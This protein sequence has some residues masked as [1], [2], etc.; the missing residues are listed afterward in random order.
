MLTSIE[1]I[2]LGLSHSQA[3]AVAPTLP[4]PRGKLG[5]NSFPIRAATETPTVGESM[6]KI[7]IGLRQS[8]ARARLFTPAEQNAR[9]QYGRG[10]R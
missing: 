7:R 2:T 3:R 9:Y 4:I 1:K 8:A 5:L 10:Q 6:E